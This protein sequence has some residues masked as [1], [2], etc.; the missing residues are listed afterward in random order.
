VKRPQGVKVFRL[1]DHVERAN[2]V[3]QAA[4]TDNTSTP[5]D[6][7]AAFRLGFPAWLA[8]RTNRDRLVITHLAVADWGRDRRHCTPSPLRQR[9]GPA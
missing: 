7:Q 2:P 1:P 3:F 8:T 5:P 4:L 9:L 6:E